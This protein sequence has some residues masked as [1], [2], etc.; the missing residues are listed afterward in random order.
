MVILR[1]KY[2]CVLL[3]SISDTALLLCINYISTNE[4]FSDSR[5]VKGQISSITSYV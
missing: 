2:F 4:T 1:I 5:Y 3:G